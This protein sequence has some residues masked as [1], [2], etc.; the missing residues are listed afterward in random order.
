MSEQERYDELRAQVVKV[1]DAYHETVH[2][3]WQDETTRVANWA[4]LR[5]E[6]DELERVV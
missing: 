5:S 4:I 3:R 2:V 1:L 6:L